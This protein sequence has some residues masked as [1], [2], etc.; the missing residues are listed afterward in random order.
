MRIVSIPS[1]SNP[2]KFYQVQVNDCNRAVACTCPDFKHRK[3]VARC[4]HFYRAEAL[5]TF[6]AALQALVEGG[7]VSN[8][9]TALAM[10]QR[11]VELNNGDFNLTI[12]QVIARVFGPFHPYAQPRGRERDLGRDLLA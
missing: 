2:D 12:S 7:I 3:E 4:K 9:P 10:F 11:K 5:D 1:D 8:L 6:N